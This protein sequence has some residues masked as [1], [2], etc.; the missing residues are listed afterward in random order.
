MQ[1]LQ[2]HSG[3]SWQSWGTP[4]GPT[5]PGLERCRH[6]FTLWPGITRVSSDK[7]LTLDVR[8]GRG[9]QKEG[10]WHLV[11]LL[12]SLPL[13]QANHPN[14]KWM[15]SETRA[16]ETEYFSHSLFFFF[17]FFLVFSTSLCNTVYAFCLLLCGSQ[18]DLSAPKKSSCSFICHQDQSD[19][20][21]PYLAVSHNCEFFQ[22]IRSARNPIFLQISIVI[23]GIK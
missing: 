22:L 19:L 21:A 12:I 10:S 14:S 3:I 5:D 11:K 7:A 15:K 9:S 16:P 23:T 18:T 1:T 13:I 4:Q 17:S 8:D 20:P 6:R 2:L